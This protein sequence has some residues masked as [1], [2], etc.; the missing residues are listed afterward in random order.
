MEYGLR[1]GDAMVESHNRIVN[2]HL[3]ELH[4]T[5]LGLSN[6]QFMVAPARAGASPHFHFASARL[7]V[8]GRARFAP[9]PPA[10]AAAFQPVLKPVLP[11]QSSSSPYCAGWCTTSLA[12]ARTAPRSALR[13]WQALLKPH[14]FAAM[15]RNVALLF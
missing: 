5:G 11:Y 9:L 15:C 13:V 2:R 1:E 10:R 12:P 7:M 6:Y 3:A 8:H 4:H 14:R